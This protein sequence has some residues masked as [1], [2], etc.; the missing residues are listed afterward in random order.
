MRILPNVQTIMA[1]NSVKRG[2]HGIVCGTPQ[3]RQ[4][5]MGRLGES[6][7]RLTRNEKLPIHQFS[8]VV[9]ERLDSTG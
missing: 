5:V 4:N 1:L 8:R 9:S 3:G 6:W 2:L 7:S